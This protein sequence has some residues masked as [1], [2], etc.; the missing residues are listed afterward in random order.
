[1]NELERIQFLTR[2]KQSWNLKEAESVLNELLCSDRQVIETDRLKKS[3]NRLDDIEVSR[4]D[5]GEKRAQA[6][7]EY[8]PE[9]IKGAP[10]TTAKYPSQKRGKIL[11]K[12]VFSMQYDKNSELMDTLNKLKQIAEIYYKEDPDVLIADSCKLISLDANRVMSH[13]HDIEMLQIDKIA[14]FSSWRKSLMA[15]YR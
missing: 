15:K 14:A 13:Y 3:V 11:R 12:F 7:K 8:N 1:M 10:S 9:E 5:A 6:G 4:N 2:G